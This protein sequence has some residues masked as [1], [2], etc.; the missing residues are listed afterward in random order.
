MSRPVVALVGRTNVG[1]S[2]LLNRIVGSRYAVV[3]DQPHVTRDRLIV[4]V[5]WGD[6]D[7]VIVDTGGWG[8]DAGSAM[9]V[10]VKQQAE[11]A[12][13]RADVLVLVVAVSDGLI[14]SDVE[15][16]G[17]VRS[18]AKASILVVNKVDHERHE[19]QA[20]E[21][22]QLGIEPVIP[23]SALH[24]RGIDEFM[25]AVVG[26]LPPSEPPE[27][28]A[29]DVIRVAIVGR[30]NAG[31]STLLNAI[32][33]DDRAI[34]DEAPGTTRDSLDAELSWQGRRFVLV[35]TAG[36]RKR[37]RIDYGVDYFS[38]LRAM[39]AIDRCDVALLVLDATEPATAQDVT[40]SRYVRE[41]GRGLILVVNKWD[42]VPAEYR[43]AHK[44]WMRRRLEFLSFVPVLH[45][46]AKERRNVKTVLQRAFEVWKARGQRLARS[47]V[48]AVIQ[49]A[50]ERHSPPRVGTR[51]LNVVW[52]HQDATDP[53]RFVLH[54]N[55][56]ALVPS[57]YE[58]YLERELRREFKYNGVPLHLEF[59]PA[60]RRY[61][62]RK[63]EETS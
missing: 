55:D 59:V 61:R 22:H 39:Q 10:K 60:G 62:H 48:D 58:R 42:L 41:S 63:E 5:S 18:A 13:A 8:L 30:P 40:I 57:T 50:I 25:N 37:S 52:A 38:V 17:L 27:P 49:A 6:R 4:P 36:I 14:A 33:N 44:D 31:K 43:D 53:W 45:V 2:T 56:P 11:I 26:M 3:D 54:V 16:A 23:V 46:S 35:D 47:T 1:K 24:N 21:F 15:A 19:S 34:V 9:D 28:Y 51:R 32:L 20:G 29:E 7:L 12:I